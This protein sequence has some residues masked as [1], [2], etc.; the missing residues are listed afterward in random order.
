MINQ[1]KKSS[2]AGKQHILIGVGNRH[3]EPVEMIVIFT[4]WNVAV[5][6]VMD[7]H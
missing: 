4:G 2:N 3:G 5:L 7:V 1:S 6:A